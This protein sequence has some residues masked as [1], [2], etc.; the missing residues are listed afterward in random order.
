MVVVE[1]H[2]SSVKEVAF[3]NFIRF[4]GRIGF[5]QAAHN[6]GRGG[7]QGGIATM[8]KKHLNLWHLQEV[9]VE[10]CG[11]QA[12]A[13]RLQGVDLTIVAIYL[14]CGEGPNGPTNVQLLGQLKAFLV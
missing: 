13:I 7:T 10:G 6:S 3:Q 12:S 9:S 2:Q 11:W 8:A 5:V 1:H 14:K 4:C